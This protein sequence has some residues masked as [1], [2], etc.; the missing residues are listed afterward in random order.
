MKLRGVN[1]IT[2]DLL[3]QELFTVSSRLYTMNYVGTTK[4]L[5]DKRERLKKRLKMM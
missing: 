3:R 5:L 1:L 4:M 2:N